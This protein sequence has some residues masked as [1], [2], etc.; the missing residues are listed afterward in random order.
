[1][2][3]SLIQTLTLSCFENNMKNNSTLFWAEYCYF[4]VEKKAGMLYNNKIILLLK[5]IGMMVRVL[6]ICHGNICR[7]PMAEFILKDM[8]RR[9][10]LESKIFVESAAATTEEIGN[11]M[12]PP[13]KRKLKEKGIPFQSRR[14]RIMTKKDYESFDLIV[15]MDEENRRDMCRICGRDKD[16]KISLLM[17]WADSSRDVA[18]PWYTGNFEATYQDLITGCTAL[19]KK[20]KER[21]R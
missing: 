5:E 11:D 15:G 17:D 9:D 1:M 20:V 12:Y 8:I 2:W 21:V 13:A 16:G 4:L 3:D 18:D 6:F 10:G 7:S 14:A 19:L